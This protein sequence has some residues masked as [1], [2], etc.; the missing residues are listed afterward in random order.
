MLVEWTEFKDFVDARNAD[1]LK[2]EKGDDYYLYAQENNLQIECIINKSPSDTTDLD[3]FETN[4]LDLCNPYRQK[5][6]V[7]GKPYARFAIAKEGNVMQTI[8]FTFSTS[9]SGSLSCY[10]NDNS[11]SL[12]SYFT[13]TMYKADG[14]TTSTNILCVR[15]VI[16]FMPT[17]DYELIGGAL[18][19]KSAPLTTIKAWMTI[20]PGISSSLGG[21]HEIATGGF[22]ISYIGGDKNLSLDGKAPKELKYNSGAGS[23][24]IRGDFYHAAGTAHEIMIQLR[25]FKTPIS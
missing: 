18:W 25:Y 16:D 6:D 22:D 10:K 5:F 1:I 19:S 13:Y 21:N 24:K 9:T 23:N 20:A 17:F 4:Y 3:D 14:T 2:V 12:G 11:T 8:S 15:T 7:S